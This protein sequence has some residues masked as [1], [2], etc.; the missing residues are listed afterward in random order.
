VTVAVVLL[1]IGLNL[2]R[3]TASPGSRVIP[4]LAVTNPL[5]QPGGDAAPAEAYEVYSA[6]YQGP[7]AEPLA[8]AVDSMTDIP[9]INGSCLR[10]RTAQER[11]MMD[12]FEAANRQSHTWEQKFTIAAGY[13][14]LSK[15]DANK[16][17]NCI[18]GREQG[19]AAGCE[20]FTLLRHVRF[21]GVPGFDGTRTRAL[22]SVVKMCG[23]ECGSGG[24]FEV[25]KVDGK[26]RRAEA[27]DF[28]RNCSWL[29]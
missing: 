27:S 6:L 9:Q 7:A 2:Q 20:S 15:N 4:D 19:P 25:E 12:A 1:C 3:W 16:A 21:L 11:E 23:G 10:P 26:W 29:Y 28:T 5:N 13:R 17:Q 18:V 14:L 24:I 22:V 8:F